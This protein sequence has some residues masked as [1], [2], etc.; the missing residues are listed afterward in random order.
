MNRYRQREFRR[1]MKELMDTYGIRSLDMIAGYDVNGRFL[2]A[3]SHMSIWPRDESDA[4]DADEAIRHALFAD[5]MDKALAAGDWEKCAEIHSKL[6]G[7]VAMLCVECDATLDG[8][9]KRCK[10][11][12]KAMCETCYEIGDG[13]CAECEYGGVDGA[14]H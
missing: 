14:A 6:Y 4:K 8:L 12:G 9:D 11:C 3:T 5:A 2:T 1:D 13:K 10:R 7:N